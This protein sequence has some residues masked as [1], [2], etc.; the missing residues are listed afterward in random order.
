MFRFGPHTVSGY[1]AALR[2]A[3]RHEHKPD[4]VAA[5]AFRIAGPTWRIVDL[6][7]ST[8]HGLDK[9]HPSGRGRGKRRMAHMQEWELAEILDSN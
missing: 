9:R 8:L 1:A 7:G 4:F 5:N 6:D 3:A 2:A